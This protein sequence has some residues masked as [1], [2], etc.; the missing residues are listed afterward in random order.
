MSKSN[1]KLLCH[2]SEK[3]SSRKININFYFVQLYLDTNRPEKE[4][5][6]PIVG[7]EMYSKNDETEKI[8]KH[9]VVLKEPKLLGYIETELK[10]RSLTKWD[11]LY[12]KVVVLLWRLPSSDE[13]LLQKS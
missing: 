10:L 5:H 4:V 8:Q 12:Q 3:V 2:S 13:T 6:S 1:V 7:V 11:K 9:A